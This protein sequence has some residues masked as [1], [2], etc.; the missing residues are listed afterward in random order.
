MM[1]CSRDSLHI[2]P[3]FSHSI[4]VL[5]V[6]L[7]VLASGTNAGA[8]SLQ[9]PAQRARGVVPCISPENPLQLLVDVTIRRESSKVSSTFAPV[10]TDQ[11]SP[12][13]TLDI[14]P[15]EGEGEGEGEGQSTSSVSNAAATPVT[16]DNGGELL[17]LGC[18]ARCLQSG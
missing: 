15:L 16:F 13:E 3:S 8:R 12:G 5:L 9:Q 4:T 10:S 17:H 1:G 7:A 11:A 2:P 18:T 6:L 14:F